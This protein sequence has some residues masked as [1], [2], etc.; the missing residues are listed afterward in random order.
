MSPEVYEIG[1]STYAIRCVNDKYE[2]LQLKRGQWVIIDIDM[3]YDLAQIK[4]LYAA[5]VISEN[6]DLNMWEIVGKRFL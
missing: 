4:L 3:N 1:K 2:V 5:S 6:A